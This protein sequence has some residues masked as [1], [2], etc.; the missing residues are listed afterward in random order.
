MIGRTLSQ[1]EVHGVSWSSL[2]CSGSRHAHK[3]ML[4]PAVRCDVLSLAALASLVTAALIGAQ[5]AR[6][7]ADINKTPPAGAASGN[8]ALPLT[9]GNYSYFVARTDPTG[10]EMFRTNGTPGHSELVADIWAGPQSSSPQGFTRLGSKYLFTASTVTT[11]RELFVLDPAA[12]SKPVRLVSDIFTGAP[13]SDPRNLHVFQGAVYFSANFWRLSGGNRSAGSELWKSDGTA[14]GTV[15]VKEIDQRCPWNAPCFGGAPSD[16]VEFSGMLYFAATS[17][18]G[19]R[20]IW[21][22]DGTTAGTV[23][24]IEVVPGVDGSSP[25]ELLVFKGWLYFRAYSKAYGWDLY[26]STGTTAG[27]ARLVLGARVD[28]PNPRNFYGYRGELFFMA[29]SAA[30]GKELWKTDGTTFTVFDL[31]PGTGSSS[32][33]LFGLVGKAPNEKLVFRASTPALGRELW[34][35]DGKTHN[36]ID[37]ATGADSAMSY[38]DFRDAAGNLWLNAFG[39]PALGYELYKTDGTVAGTVLI[40]DIRTTTSR[41]NRTASSSPNWFFYG[42]RGRILFGAEDDSHGRELWTTDGTTAGTVLHTDLNR[43]GKSL[44]SSPAD[45][46]DARGILYFAATTGSGLRELWKSDGTE[47]GTTGIPG[48]AVAPADL[49]VIGHQLFFTGEAAATGR[50]LYVLDLR[51]DQLRRIDIA[52]GALGSAPAELIGFR[53]RAYFSAHTAAAGRELFCSDGTVAGTVRVR[54]IVPGA[55]GSM[56]GSFMVYRDRLFFSA[57]TAALGRELWSAD[58][59]TTGTRLAVDILPGVEGS[60][61]RFSTRFGDRLA[62]LSSG[63]GGR[64]NLTLTDGTAAGTTHVYTGSYATAGRTNTHFAVA[65]GLL[66]FEGYDSVAGAEL[67]KTDGSLAGTGLVRDIYGGRATSA[68]TRI[69]ANGDHVVFKVSINRATPLWRSDGTAA[70]T[71]AVYG[72]S[73]SKAFL[74]SAMT[75]AGSRHVVFTGQESWGF[76][77][78]ITDGTTAGSRRFADLISGS[79]GSISYRTVEFVVS[80]GKVFFAAQ[81]LYRGVELFVADIGAVSQAIGVGCASGANPPQLLATDPVI[82]ASMKLSLSGKANKAG[83]LLLG[84]RAVPT[85]PWVYGGGCRVFLDLSLP[86]LPLAVSTGAGGAWQLTVAVPN[87]TQLIGLSVAGQA[88]LGPAATVPL[89][90]DLSNGVLLSIGR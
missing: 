80:G 35:S 82:G 24:A 37:I 64:Q 52:P 65:N 59:T 19:G 44:S 8:P 5:S 73:S 66:F 86:Q 30:H 67:F 88:A 41:Y 11:G 33:G 38:G 69:T 61:P 14:A 58:G 32:P 53:D 39:G 21:K 45:L 26:R 43:G 79:S 42:P 90:A 36:P 74:A 25:A 49:Q 51:N 47:R 87:D 18:A 15:L 16:F 4:I 17:A 57:T 85:T 29:R 75:T 76:E 20:E 6:L 2:Q 83:L 55:A 62:C 23:Q 60:K 13:S 1:V 54:D 12:T 84:P 7:V 9:I 40:K 46:V 27:T 50:E 31:V 3:P 78:Y 34:V 10:S 56:P 70:G 63:T 71:V 81:D 48:S 72:T 77:P 28:S 22:T 89:G 68:P